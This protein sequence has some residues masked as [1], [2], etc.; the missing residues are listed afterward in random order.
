MA[1]DMMQ[2]PADASIG[3]DIGSVAVTLRSEA[4]EDFD[5]LE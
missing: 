2:P 5:M 1:S 4:R 3:I